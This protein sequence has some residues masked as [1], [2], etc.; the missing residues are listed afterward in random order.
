MVWEI[1][2]GLEIHA[3]LA[4]KSKIFS[5]ASTAYGAE[6]NTQACAV[7][8]GLPGVLP[9]LNKE[10]VRMATKFGLA[11][12]AD[13]SRRSVF[14]RKNYFYPDLPKGY[15]ISQMELLARWNCRL[16]VKGNLK[17]NWKMARR[18]SLVLRAHTWKRMPVNLCM[19][20]FRA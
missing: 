13:V 1:V 16:L 6:P 14:A 10:A 18:S 15:Q 3:Q 5:G 19:E 4:T 2:I 11:I 20:N 8:L 9:V 7:D 12:D 17:L